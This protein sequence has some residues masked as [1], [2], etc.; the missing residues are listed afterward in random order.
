MSVVL[1]LV[2]GAL[3][4]LALVDVAITALP[5]AARGGPVTAVIAKALWRL[6]PRQSETG[7]HHKALQAAS[8]TIVVAVLAS[9]VVL[10]WGG[11]SLVF[12]GGDTAVVDAASGRPADGWARVYYAGFS[13]F[14]LGT[15]DYR[16]E[17][18]P[19]QVASVVSVLTGMSVLTLAV[20]YVLGVVSAETHKRQVASSIAAM[21]TSPEAV[22]RRAWDGRSLR[23]LDAHLRTIS[24]ELSRLAQQHFAYPV[25]HYLH[26][27]DVET[28]VPPNVARLGEVARIVRADLPD[29][30]VSALTLQATDSAISSLLGTREHVHDRPTEQTPPPADLEAL[31][32]GGLPVPENAPTRL[33]DS[34]IER[35]E[36]L[37]GLVYTDGWRWDI[38]VS[39][40][41][42]TS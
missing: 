42:D 40:G 31:R 23:G 12:L 15:G 11:W 4:V 1:V 24:A 5:A 3:V 28:S 29:V 9:W 27:T 16:P 26:S 10:L 37:L 35:R 18:A 25:L 6:P 20:T 39:P 36:R 14:S 13:T 34:E 32:A 2:G 38:H 17:G 33:V 8:F 21:G 7:A 30:G 19:W 41:D 22:L